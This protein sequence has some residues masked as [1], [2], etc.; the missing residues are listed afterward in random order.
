M[1]PAAETK[2]LNGKL[3]F[4]S[5]MTLMGGGM[6]YGHSHGNANLPLALAGGMI[7]NK[8]WNPCRF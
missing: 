8:T 3:F 7:G 5:T 4:D 1:L 2:D 6:A